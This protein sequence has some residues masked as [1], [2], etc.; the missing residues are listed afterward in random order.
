MS[1]NVFKSMEIVPMESR[2]SIEIPE[3]NKIQVKEETGE[4]E[5]YE[6]KTIE[7]LKREADEFEAVDEILEN[8]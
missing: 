4:I 1:K 5:T 2:V 6:G 7:D 3:F 8:S